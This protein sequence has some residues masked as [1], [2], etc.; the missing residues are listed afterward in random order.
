MNDENEERVSAR[1]GMRDVGVSVLGT[2]FKLIYTLI[3]LPLFCAY[4]VYLDALRRGDSAFFAFSQLTFLGMSGWWV[5]V[6]VLTRILPRLRDATQA[7][8]WRFLLVYHVIL[9]IA[10]TVFQL[11]LVPFV[12]SVF[13]MLPGLVL[14]GV[15]ALFILSSGSLAIYFEPREVYEPTE[16][17]TLGMTKTSADRAEQ[18]A[19][20]TREKYRLEKEEFSS[21]TPP[22]AEENARRT[23]ERTRE[24]NKQNNI[25]S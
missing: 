21:A 10:W 3:S 18:N 20:R 13:N 17:I 11:L 24:A 23:L 7:R 22:T 1:E 25:N 19:H 5:H 15:L 2:T 6:N 16:Q 14:K 9:A 12:D 8:P 4:P